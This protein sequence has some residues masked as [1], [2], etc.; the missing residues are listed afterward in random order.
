MKS[1]EAEVATAA[2]TVIGSSNPY[3]HEDRAQYWLATVGSGDA[4]GIGKM[5]PDMKNAGGELF[6]TELVEVANSQRPAAIRAL[7]VRALGLVRDDSLTKDVERWLTDNAPPVR[8]SAAVLLADF[9]GVE[10]GKK[11]ASLASDAAPEVRASA[12]FAIGFAQ[13]AELAKTMGML[14]ADKDATVRRGACLSLLSFSPNHAEIADV[15]R[16]NIENKEFHPLFLNALAADQTE[17]YLE[18]LAKAV[19]QKAEPQNWP[20]GQVPAF[21]AFNILFKYLQSL[22]EEALQQGKFERYLGALEKGYS[23]GSSEPRDIYAF[24]LQ[25]GMT[26]RAKKYREAAKKAVTYD[27][28]Y[29]FNQVDQD[30]S[31]YTR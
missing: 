20:G 29:F 4:P 26:E 9:R 3:M 5:E 11:L 28:D 23:T 19:E 25:R 13:R 15:F 18:P 16:A 8:A 6:K 7:A 1:D 31:R 30:P 14:L 24:Y 22:P 17:T 27:L 12:A 2:I 10:I 21:T